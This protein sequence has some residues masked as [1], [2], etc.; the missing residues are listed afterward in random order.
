MDVQNRLKAVEPRL[1]Q[2]VRQDGLSVESASSS[3]LMIVGLNS[4][5]GRFDEIALNDYM[6]RN[7][8]EELRR[9]DGVGRVQ[10]FGAEQAMRIWIEPEKLIAFGLSVN[11]L[12]TA[13]TE[14]NAPIVPGSIGAS[15]SVPGQ[16]VTS[17]LTA[18]GQ[19]STSRVGRPILRL[20]QS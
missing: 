4:D 15:P 1:P 16:K 12:S 19:L 10:L 18:Q 17:L 9:I 6:A 13:I 7:I 5:D 2:A 11:D 20:L 14:Q 3:F 8:V